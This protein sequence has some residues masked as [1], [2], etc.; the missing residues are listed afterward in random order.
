M[1]KAPPSAKRDRIKA[2]VPALVD[3]TETPDL[4]RKD[5]ADPG[6]DAP[7]QTVPTLKSLPSGTGSKAAT[8]PEAGSTA[9][10]RTTPSA[11]GAHGRSA[12]VVASNA[13]RLARPAPPAW[14]A[15]SATTR[16]R[17]ASVS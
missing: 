1:A 16:S 15:R 11:L 10:A 3:Y 6:G 13:A 2:F 17:P 9:R 8:T 5:P 12:P 14:P 4:I 7:V